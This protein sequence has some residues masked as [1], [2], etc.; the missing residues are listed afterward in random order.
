MNHPGYQPRLTLTDKFNLIAGVILPAIAITVE[1]STHLCAETFFDPIPTVWHLML[2]IFVPLGH[3]HVWFT[4]RR[5]VPDRLMLAGFVNAVVI[6]ISIF[7]SITYLQ[8]VPLAF[9]TVL[10]VVGLLPLSPFLSLIAALTMRQQ[11]RRIAAAGPE[12]SFALRARGLLI[13]LGFTFGLIGLVELPATLTRHG[14]QMAA[15]PSP[16]SKTEGIRFLRKYGSKDELLQSCYNRSRDA[17]DML[18]DLLAIESPV[19]VNEARKIYYRV[20]GETFDMSVPPRRVAGHLI[21]QDT[22]DF[23]DDQGGTKI[24]GKIKGLSLSISKLEGS[25]DA[26]G[27]VGYLQWTLTFQNDSDRAQQARAEIQLPPGGIVSSVAL[28]ENDLLRTALIGSRFKGGHESEVLQYR[29]NP[30]LVT[31]AGRDRVLVQA[32]NV[33]AYG[34]ERKVRLGITVPLLL[35]SRSHARLLLPHFE[36]RNFRIPDDMNHLIW[37]EATRPI[38]TEYGGLYYGQMPDNRFVL[39][40]RLTDRELSGPER[41]LL[42]AR[43]DDDTG[44]W[45]ENPFEVEGS[46]VKQWIEERTPA[47]LRRIVLVV[48]TSASMSQWEPEIN[49][50]LGALPPEIDLKLVLADS[51]WLHENE[52]KNLVA[53]GLESVST[54][55]A[56]TTFSGGADNAPALRKAWDLAAEA[57]GNNAIVWIHS[58]QLVQLESTEALRRRWESRPYGPL[59]YSVQMSRGSDEI[60]KKLDGINEVKSVVRMGTLRADLERLFGQL[61][62]QIKTLEFV[63]SVKHIQF[64]AEESEGYKTSD[65]LAQLWASDEIMRILNARDQSLNGAATSLT[66]RYQLVTPISNASVL[67]VAEQSRNPAVGPLAPGYHSQSKAEVETL[68]LSEVVFIIGL[69]WMRYRH[70]GG[71]SFTT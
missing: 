56:S 60:T 64:P 13:A 12:K 5:G 71:G 48:D 63:R 29:G 33:P 46:I 49:A 10:I 30:I 40:G 65:H 32:F 69:I 41:S 20:T 15:S 54:L 62:G 36:S 22:I 14:L 6:G 51:E 43:L 61:S 2:V 70:I 52:R 50:A 18:G 19:D 67:E 31:T 24:G 35:E 66:E 34:S 25:I 68:L 7:Y 23:E 44:T 16:Q 11:L 42:L 21:S 57:P 27:G 53:T 26:D 3:L 55:L 39:R 4:I 47:H 28:W 59:L 58:P 1:A 37:F 45:G 8:L 17:T 38:A 9:L